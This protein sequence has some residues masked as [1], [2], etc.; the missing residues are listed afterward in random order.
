[1]AGSGLFLASTS[2]AG[3]VPDVLGGVSDGQDEFG[4]QAADFVAGQRD[5]LAVACADAPFA[6]SIVRVT[7]RNAAAAMARVMWA[8]QAS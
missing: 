7:A 1:V 4:E 8:Y 6:A 5:Q 2:V 3:P